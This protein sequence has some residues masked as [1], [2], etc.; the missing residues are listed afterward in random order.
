M[1]NDSQEMF[2]RSNRLIEY[3]CNEWIASH[4]DSV[5][6][7][8]DDLHDNGQVQVTVILSKLFDV[9][10]L[11]PNMCIDLVSI[12]LIIMHQRNMRISRPLEKTYGNTT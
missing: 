4:T 8:E 3:F 9:F 10:N 7:L 2:A 1:E 6:L 5:V 12:R 11:L